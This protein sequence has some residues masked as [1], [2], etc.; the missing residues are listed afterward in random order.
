MAGSPVRTRQKGPPQ[1]GSFCFSG[2]SFTGTRGSA[3]NGSQGNG[4]G[5]SIARRFARAAGGDV[6]LLKSGAGSTTF[7]LNLPANTNSE[8][9]LQAVEIHKF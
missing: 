3:S 6:I 2:I 5:L 1:G 8:F 7:R 4:L 9:V